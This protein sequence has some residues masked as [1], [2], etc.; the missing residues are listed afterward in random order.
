MENLKV[1]PQCGAVLRSRE[2][3]PIVTGNAVTWVDSF[4]LELDHCPNCGGRSVRRLREIVR[5]PSADMALK[6]QLY[7]PKKPIHRS[8]WMV[9]VPLAI[10][11]GS[12][13][14]LFAFTVLVSAMYLAP[15]KG[16]QL[17]AWDIALCFATGLFGLLVGTFGARRVVEQRRRRIEADDRTELERWTA[18]MEAWERLYYCPDC[19]LVHDPL[20]GRNAHAYAMAHLLEK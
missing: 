12:A 3:G 5:D 16:M 10:G 11:L 14:I 1:C 4:P 7:A 20:A 17:P 13:V 19:Q 9:A 6:R 18:E 15:V 8:V 2:S